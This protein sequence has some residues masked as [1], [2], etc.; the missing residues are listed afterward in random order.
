MLQ[1]NNHFLHDYILWFKER[2]HDNC[3]TFMHLLLDKYTSL[4]TNL[5]CMICTGDLSRNIWEVRAGVTIAIKGLCRQFGYMHCRC[6]SELG[7]Q[8]VQYDLQPC[9]SKGS[10][11]KKHFFMQPGTDRA[12]Q[13]IWLTQ[14][15][16]PI[17]VWAL[18][19]RDRDYPYSKDWSAKTNSPIYQD[20]GIWC[21]LG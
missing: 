14:F 1:A 12:Q 11:L 18:L 10:S 8:L 9:T 2:I 19:I 15:K 16:T 20:A 5:I 6:Y 4:I 13:M 17:K 3:I 7:T 21:A